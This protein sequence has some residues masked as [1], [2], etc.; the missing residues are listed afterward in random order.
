MTERVLR[1][2]FEAYTRARTGGSKKTRGIGE[3]GKEGIFFTYAHSL[4]PFSPFTPSFLPRL[5]AVDFFSVTK[6]D[7]DLPLGVCQ[8][9]MRHGL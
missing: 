5:P 1:I 9:K 4:F 3:M 7:F 6:L 8:I 2:D